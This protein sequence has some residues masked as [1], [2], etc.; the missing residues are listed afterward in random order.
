MC[1]CTRVCM[2]IGGLQSLDL[3][4]P[5]IWKMKT[6]ESELEDTWLATRPI[7]VNQD[8]LSPP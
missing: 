1:V 3:E 8:I 4:E 7:A 6:E 2:G 5:I